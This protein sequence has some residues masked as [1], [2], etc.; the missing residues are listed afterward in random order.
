[1]TADPRRIWSV[2]LTALASAVLLVTGMAGAVA[3]PSTSPT[4]SPSTSPST[5]PSA[6]PSAGPSAAADARAAKA[7]RQNG[8][9]CTRG[10]NG[11]LVDCPVHVPKSQRPAGARNTSTV[12]VPVD[13]LAALV[14][15]R[16][17]TTGGGNTFP[18]A[19][20][21]FGVVQWSP[22][23]RAEPQRGRRL[24][25]RRHQDHGL[26]ADPRQRSGLRRRWRRADAADHRS[27]AQPATRTTRP[28]RSATTTRSRRPA[29]TPRRATSRT[30]SPRSSPR[31]RTARWRASPTRRGQQAGFLIKLHDSQNGD[32]APSTAKVVS[33][34]EV[35]GSDTSGDF[36]GEGTNDGQS[37]LYTVYFDII[38]DQPFTVARS[39][40]AA[41]RPRPRCT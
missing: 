5:S 6:A 20:V 13:N 27:A 21:P 16:T 2:V 7:A 3:A 17:W 23:T 38:F 10:A 28:R 33:N 14:D 8:V 39:S 31:L 12:P 9:V 40:M 11:H 34:N 4:A 18:G 36:C 41:R 25:L 24:Q 32:Y 35:S 29:T 15:T 19:I 1:M 37:Q 22:D 30:R 26:L